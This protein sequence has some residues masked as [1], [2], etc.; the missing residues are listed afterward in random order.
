MNLKNRLKDLQYMPLESLTAEELEKLIDDML[1]SIG[2]IDPELRDDLIYATLV[3]IINEDGA[4]T[5]EQYIHILDT[6]L[7]DS[8]LFYKIG[9]E[10]DDSVF[11]RSFSSL[12]I[13]AVLRVD[14]RID[15]LER[16]SFDGTMTRILTYIEQERDTRGFVHRKGWAHSIAHGAD[17][18][19]HLVRNPKF[20]N[21]DLPSIL[22][23][24]QSC[25]FKEAAYTD[26]ED[27]RLIFAIEVA[28]M[29]RDLSDDLLES[30]IYGVFAA[31]KAVF[32]VEVFSYRYHRI[33]VNVVNFMKTLFFTFKYSRTRLRIRVQILNL[34]ES[35]NRH[36]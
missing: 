2:S 26:L 35:L 21:D 18:L 16:E 34:L 17:M 25:L 27:E 30:W 5:H 14:A 1:G 31:L 32:D 36:N 11:T 15:F 8:H 20:S 23:A 33:Q 12:A 6:A 22:G 24:I 9:N 3:R 19:V 7:D 10:R 4:L 29:E 13:A 28:L